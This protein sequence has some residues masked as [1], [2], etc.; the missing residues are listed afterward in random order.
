VIRRGAALALC[1]L[2]PLTLAAADPPGDTVACRGAHG[3]GD[4]PDLIEAAG[5]LGEEG[6]TAVWRLTFSA[7][8]RVPDPADPPFR[9]D[10][11]V[12]DPRVPTVS[13][14]SYRRFNRLVRWDASDLSAGVELLFVPEG[15]HTLF[16]PP[17]IEGDTMT[18][19]MPGRLLLGTDLFG[20]VDL[21]RLR[22]SV[23]VRDGGRC[24][25]LGDGSP[26]LRLAPRPPAS[27]TWGTS[28]SSVVGAPSITGATSGD[29]S[30]LVAVAI[31]ALIAAAGALTLRRRR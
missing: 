13:V 22:W 2:L 29:R 7:P 30:G 21:Q 17:A 26:S 19:Q 18:I 25:L 12:R 5:W 23:V 28:A 8:L 27:S 9:V 31:V 11:V 4:P 16:D 6:S 24:D 15:G 3:G 20:R 1:V 14:G 10:I